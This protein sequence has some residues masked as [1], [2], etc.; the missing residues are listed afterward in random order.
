MANILPQ[1]THSQAMGCRLN[2]YAV[3]SQRFCLNLNRIATSHPQG[4]PG[5]TNGEPV[6]AP[7]SSSLPT[8]DG[9]VMKRFRDGSCPQDAKSE[10]KS[11]PNASVPFS[12]TCAYP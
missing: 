4:T 7:R 1:T 6:I 8:H 10:Q 9:Y 11:C 2:Q 5:R 12:A 3:L